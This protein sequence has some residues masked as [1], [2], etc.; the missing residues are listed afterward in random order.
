MYI[1]Q[2]KFGQRFVGVTAAETAT[3]QL[4]PLARVMLAGRAPRVMQVRFA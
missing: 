4:L 3:A 1:F 2:S